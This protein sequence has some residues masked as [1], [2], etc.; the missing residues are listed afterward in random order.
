MSLL[1]RADVDVEDEGGSCP[2]PV[3]YDKNSDPI[4]CGKPIAEG[5]DYCSR[6]W[7]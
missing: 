7:K 5:S 6:H 1:E 2:E 3:G 4:P